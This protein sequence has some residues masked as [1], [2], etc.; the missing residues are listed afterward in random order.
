MKKPILVVMAAGMGSRYGGLKQMDPM[1]QH[2]EVIMDYSLF[3]ARRAGFEK[4]IFIIKHSIED[5]FREK[6]G[7]HIEKYMTV[8]YA[9]QDLDDLPEGYSVPEGREKPWGTC[10]AILA[11][12]HLIDAPF[13]VINADDYYGSQCFRIIYDYLCTHEDDDK[14]RYCM[15]GYLLKN[16][17]TENGSVARGVCTA[18]ADGN[19]IQVVEH[20][21]IEQYDGGIHFT[22]DG[23]KTWT[24]ISGD[25]TVSMNLWGFSESFLR[26]AQ[27]RFPAFLDDALANNPIRGEYFLPSVVTQLL[28][29]G[30]ATVRVLPCPDKWYGITYREDKPMVEKALAEMAENGLYPTPLWQ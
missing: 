5:T 20:T 12:R 19:L 25:T 21:Q 22:E 17:V 7:S 4:V 13:A 23:G 2:G 18:D 8:E 10:H 11:A 24:D 28:S 6:I 29:E 1:G 30:K 16:T 27:S 9:F 14:Y 26:E 3:D 15:V